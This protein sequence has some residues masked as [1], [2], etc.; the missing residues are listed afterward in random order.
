MENWERKVMLQWKNLMDG[1][2]KMG[3]PTKTKD[4]FEDAIVDW[5]KLMYK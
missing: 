1:G 2:E 5:R 4:K 3:I